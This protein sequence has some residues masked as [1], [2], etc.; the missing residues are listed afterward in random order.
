MYATTPVRH[1]TQCTG[2]NAEQNKICLLFW[3]FREKKETSASE[4]TNEWNK[5]DLTTIRLEDADKQHKTT[6]ARTYKKKESHM[7]WNVE[8]KIWSKKNYFY[9][10][11]FCKE[12]KQGH[13]KAAKWQISLTPIQ[14]SI[15][16][17]CFFVHLSYSFPIRNY[18]PRRRFF[19]STCFFGS[20]IK[21]NLC[22]NAFWL[23]LPTTKKKKTNKFLSNAIYDNDIVFKIVS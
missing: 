10:G 18:R 6:H 20:L 12:N 1:S 5:L 22:S 19:S 14:Y 2:T 7:A 11:I 17:S 16:L 8:C 13:P 23:F 4:R 9:F 15:F 21:M 3:V